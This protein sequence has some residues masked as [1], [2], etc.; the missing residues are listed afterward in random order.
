MKNTIKNLFCLSII[1]LLAGCG[2]QVTTTSKESKQDSSSEITSSSEAIS[3]SSASSS[4]KNPTTSR[5]TTT[6]RSSSSSSKANATSTPK[7]YVDNELSSASGL[8]V[9][10]KATGATIDK[11]TYS[12]KTIAKDGFVVGRCA[13]RIANGKFSIDGTQYSVSINA[14]PHSLHGGAGS[15][16]NSWRGPFA[17]KD[18]TKVEQTKTSITYR[19]VSADKENGYPGEMT[20]TVKYTLS[21]EGD[22]S[23]EYTATTTK[24][25]L[26]NPTN[27]LFM[28]MN[29]NN[30][31][32]NIKLWIDADKYTPLSNQI[33]T[34]AISSVTGTQFDYTTEKT[35]DS[36]KNYDDN[37]VLNGTGY[38]KVA[39]MTGTTLKMKVDVYTDR[40]GLQLYKDGSGNICLETQ[41]FPDMINHPEFADYGTT[42]LR[43]GE[44]FNSKTTYSFTHFE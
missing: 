5:V 3:S 26:C 31:Y 20:M 19:I 7:D 25:T 12:G 36:S 23:I 29:G 21:A 11:I 43:A 30:S 10:F 44:T 1:S 35:F 17:T 8:T 41:M 15:G 28:A 33:P 9:K 2:M 37:Y 6:S 16:M 27:H 24:D 14:S 34:G 39:T 42:I 22:L 40:P 38:R 4:S 32:D 18:W 13:N